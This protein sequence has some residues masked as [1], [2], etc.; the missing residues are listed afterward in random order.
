MTIAR[1]VL[2]TLYRE[3][4]EAVGPCPTQVITSTDQLVE[5][6]DDMY[7]QTSVIRRL[8]A[9]RNHIILVPEHFDMQQFEYYKVGD[10]RTLSVVNEYQIYTSGVSVFNHRTGTKYVAWVVNVHD[11]ACW[12]KDDSGGQNKN[13]HPKLVNNATSNQKETYHAYAPTAI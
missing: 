9:T 2:E 3:N 4:N 13:T 10:Y 12:M 11:S 8:M 1:S 6:C 5:T 7:P